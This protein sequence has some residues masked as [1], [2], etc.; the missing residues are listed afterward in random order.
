VKAAWPAAA[1]CGFGG[2]RRE[3]RRDGKRRE[4]EDRRER[5]GATFIYQTETRDE[6]K[7]R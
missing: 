5:G 4:R 2:G 1:R 6:L 3:R 7:A